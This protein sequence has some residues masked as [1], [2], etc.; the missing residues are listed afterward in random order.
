MPQ[1]ILPNIH[2]TDGV[3][4]NLCQRINTD[5][6]ILLLSMQDDF[7][8]NPE[9]LTLAGKKYIIID[10]IENGWN[11]NREET[12]IV[13]DNT[14]NFDSC[15]GEGWKLLHEFVRDNPPALY[16]KRELLYKDW[17]DTIKPIEYPN[18]QPEYLPQ[19]R[20]EFNGRPISMLWFWGRS[21]E[22]RLMLQG[23]I[24]KNAARKGYAVCD[25]IFQ[26]NHFMEEETNPNKWITLH[27]PHY[28]RIPI[29]E[30]LK[31][32]GLS[33]LSVSLPGAGVKCFRSTGESIVNSVCIFPEDELAYSYDF[34]NGQN[35]IIFPIKS[36]DGISEEWDVCGAIEKALRL[37]NLYEIYLESLKVA[38]W[39]RVDNYVKNYLEKLINKA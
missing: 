9:V 17:C 33:K 7:S 28:S 8:L 21:H 36:V 18:F 11:W 25:N 20:E 30:L 13:G 10:Y 16:L 4:N 15:K 1:I 6:P 27:I 22:A 3:A 2:R 34:V 29:T 39:Y 37:P 26:F 35:C 23:E 12:L 19:T 38:S 5:L 24:W 32:N 31:I 14:F